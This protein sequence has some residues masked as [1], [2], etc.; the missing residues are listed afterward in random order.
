MATPQVSAAPEPQLRRP[1]DLIFVLDSSGSIP[2]ED[3]DRA[4]TFTRRI[5]GL[6]DV[7]QT[8]TRVA[9]VN[10]GSNAKVEF[11]LHHHSTEEQVRGS[12][13]SVQR[14]GCSKEKS[15]ACTSRR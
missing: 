4:L 12:R 6:L 11:S 5:V 13:L 10:F 8:G 2:E 3:L 1:R 7:S 15:T 9:M 14:A